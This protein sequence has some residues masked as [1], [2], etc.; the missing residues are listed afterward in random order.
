MINP[1]LGAKLQ[2]R[3]VVVKDWPVTHLLAGPRVLRIRLLAGV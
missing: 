1:A 2:S 3:S